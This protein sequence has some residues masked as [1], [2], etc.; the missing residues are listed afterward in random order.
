MS[1]N[2]NHDKLPPIPPGGQIIQFTETGAEEMRRKQYEKVQPH[3]NEL[4]QENM[5]EAQAI[6][7]VF[8]ASIQNCGVSST[9][10][11]FDTCMELAHRLAKENAFRARVKARDLFDELGFTEV[12]A[13]IVRASKRAGVE[14]TPSRILVDGEK[15]AAPAVSED[16][17]KILTE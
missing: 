16:A 1:K 9:L 12:P 10:G 17:P 14:L 11:M 7:M 8:S 15:P 2:R 5:V 3:L 13:H 6:N 4:N